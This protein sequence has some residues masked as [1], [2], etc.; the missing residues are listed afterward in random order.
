LYIVLVTFNIV[1]LERPY[2]TDSGLGEPVAYTG[3]KATQ[4]SKIKIRKKVAAFFRN[5][6]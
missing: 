4:L 5:F 2:T 1:I 6:K 3:N